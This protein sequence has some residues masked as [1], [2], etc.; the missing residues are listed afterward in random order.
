MDVSKQTGVSGTFQDVEVP[1]LYDSFPF[2]PTQR[3]YP[4]YKR[5]LCAIVTF[6]RKY[7]YVCKHPFKPAVVH[8]N[9]KLITRF[10]DSNLYEGI[11]GNWAD[12]L[13]RL[14]IIIQYIPEPRNKV[15][16]GLSRTLFDLRC[17]DSAAVSKVKHELNDKSPIWIWKDG[18]DGF[19]SFLA[20]LNHSEQ[21]EVIDKGTL[22]GVSVFSLE[23]VANICPLEAIGDVEEP[24]DPAQI[25]TQTWIACYQNSDWFGE[26]YRFLTDALGAL[27]PTAQ[28]LQK[29]FNHRIVQHVLWIFR[30]G[31]YLPCV[32]EGKILSLLEEAYDNSGHWGKAGTVA[33]LRGCYWPN[34]SQD[35]ERYIAGCLE[36]AKHGPATRFQFLNPVMVTYPFQL[37][38]MD[39]VGPLKTTREGNTHILNLVCYFSRFDILSAT[40][41]ANV[42]DVILCLRRTFMTYRKPFTIYCDRGQHFFNDELKEFLH[43]EG[44]NITFSSSGSSKS[45]GMIKANNK[46]LEAVLRKDSS[47]TDLEWDQRFPKA[48]SSVNSR[49]IEHL[50]ISS[51]S[52]L[53]GQAQEV[54][55]NASTLH[56]LSG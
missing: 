38:G 27:T 42:E 53:F 48:G 3:K 56:A 35:I 5:E 40:K 13:R 52:I 29:A 16:Y 39:F 26:V 49:T 4:I 36:C 14:N 23:V 22:Y 25:D 10:L 20:T 46:L 19:D 51:T 2:G 9:H 33:H 12:H 31:S 34:Q 28:L 18:K 50:G 24:L 37:L 6:C 32:P 43:L 55:A 47:Q 1:L 17:S 15:A 45:T 21:L 7:D 44:I 8:T 54:T 30:R 11:Y 41:A